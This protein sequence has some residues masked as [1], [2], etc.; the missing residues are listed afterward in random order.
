MEHMAHANTRSYLS[1]VRETH[2]VQLF[3]HN[4]TS[5]YISFFFLFLFIRV[6]SSCCSGSR[7]PFS[8]SHTPCGLIVSGRARACINPNP[9]QETREGLTRTHVMGTL[10]EWESRVRCRVRRIKTSGFRLLHS[11]PAAAFETPRRFDPSRSATEPGI[12]SPGDY[13]HGI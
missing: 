12:P 9:I 6:P 5:V 2:H 13:S 4:C 3:S 10:Q 1:E 8:L 11:L 7:L